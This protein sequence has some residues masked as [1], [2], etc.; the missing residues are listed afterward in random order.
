MGLSGQS[1]LDL[2]TGT[3]WVAREFARRGAQVAGCDVSVEQIEEARVVA[4]ADGVS[5]DF[6]VA[7][8]EQLP[9]GDAVFD[10][11]I[12]MQCWIYFDLERVIPELRRVVKP[13][14]QVVVSHFSFLPRLDPIARASEAL[15]L[16]FNP[17]WGGADWDGTVPLPLPRWAR[18][19]LEETDHF[20]YDEAIPFTRESWRGRMRALRGVGASL[21]PGEIQ[22]FDERH[23][24][25][26][27]ASTE[28]SFEV[29]HRIDAYL[30]R[31]REAE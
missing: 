31:F 26:L 24:E 23:A 21:D 16:E 14:G 25:L 2:G 7:P 15:V 11:A 1:L 22:R 27:E 19:Q 29:L 20:V 4:R 8:A 5:V 13:G 18:E 28:E 10:G 3:G 9:F 17:D 6:R 30:F 12:A